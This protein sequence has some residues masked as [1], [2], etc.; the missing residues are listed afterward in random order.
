MELHKE[1][2]P[3]LNRVIETVMKREVKLRWGEDAMEDSKKINE[4]KDSRK[5]GWQTAH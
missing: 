3:R 1:T 5:R 2:F 4:W